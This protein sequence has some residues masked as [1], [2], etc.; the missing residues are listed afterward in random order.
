MALEKTG[1]APVP[2]KPVADPMAKTPAVPPPAAKVSPQADTA[3]A[4][5]ASQRAQAPRGHV[6]PPQA[7]SRDAVERM[8]KQP[9]SAAARKGR[10]SG[11]N[12]T[13][14]R[15]AHDL[16]WKRAGGHGDSPPAFIY[17]K[18]VYLDPSRWPRGQ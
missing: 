9:V 5:S 2:A 4:A 3:A 13:I 6:D 14:D 17:D 11:V 10:G 18:Q 7:I 8:Q 1:Q 16:A 15:E 12:Y